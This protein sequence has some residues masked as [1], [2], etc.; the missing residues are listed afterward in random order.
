MKTNIE[1]SIEAGF[2]KAKKGTLIG[3]E[4][5]A[6]YPPNKVVV[7]MTE[8]QVEEF[9]ALNRAANRSHA[10]FSLHKGDTIILSASVVPG[11]ERAVERMKDGLAR[12]GV[13]II[14]YRTAGED[15]V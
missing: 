4:E 14:S 3:I 6:S 11:N 13:R 9:A 5:A 15:Y 10:K 1:V 7:L 12:Q 2:F 8:A